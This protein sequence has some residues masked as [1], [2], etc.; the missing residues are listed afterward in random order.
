MIQLL[1]TI[2]KALVATFYSSNLPVYLIFNGTSSEVRCEKRHIAS[3]KE[4]EEE[5]TC[6]WSSE[7]SSQV[8]VQ[9]WKTSIRRKTTRFSDMTT[10]V[11]AAPLRLYHQQKSELHTSDY[12]DDKSTKIFQPHFINSELFWQIVCTQNDSNSGVYSYNYLTYCNVIFYE[13]FSVR[14]YFNCPFIRA[15]AFWPLVYTHKDS[16]LRVYCYN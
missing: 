3:E 12:G 14:N 15:E 13:L 2:W 16:N 7:G 6:G 1:D 10:V 9:F 4:T 11:T 8:V 5:C